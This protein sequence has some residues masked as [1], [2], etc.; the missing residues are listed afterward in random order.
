MKHVTAW[1]SVHE[2][3]VLKVRLADGALVVVSF[4]PDEVFGSEACLGA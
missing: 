3:M 1:K 2:L 4:V